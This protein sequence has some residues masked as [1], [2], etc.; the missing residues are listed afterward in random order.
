[1]LDSDIRCDAV[2][3]GAG[4]TGAM[5]ARELVDAG[6]DTV[7]VD[8]REAAW[9]STAAST[10][11][12]QYEID[13]P[14]TDLTAMRGRDQAARAYFACR[15]AV[16]KLEQVTHV[17]GVD[18]GFERKRSLYLATR[19]EDRDKLRAECEARREIGIHVDFLSEDDISA[20]FPFRRPAALLSYDAAQVDTYAFAHAL[21]RYGAARGLRVFD[22]TAVVDVEASDRGV[23]ALTA[24]RCT[25]RARHL[26]F[27]SG[28]ETRDFLNEPV[29]KL[30]STY[31]FASEPLSSRD[32]WG[33][34]ECLI[35]E[36]ARP[37][38]YLRTTSDHRIVVGGEDEPFRDPKR[39]DRLL[40]AKTER[41]VARSKELL[42]GTDVRTAFA[43]TGTFGET[44]DGL[45]YIGTHPDWPSSY[46][47]LCYGG[48]GITFGVLAAEIVRD[49]VRGRHHPNAD[50]FRFER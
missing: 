14:L 25:V 36:C 4:I 3:L 15:D 44:K 6:F 10:G 38:L 1:M 34:D 28:Y 20:L 46:F 43:W 45:A 12:L 5:V 7:V 30:A 39:R 2:V 49:A 35:W 24:N 33:E 19:P 8:R 11:L 26:V 27:A 47:A 40:A 23:K 42:P 50:L 32:A 31:A 48:N 13:V 21:L 9:G 17:V 41:L 18:V 29:A 16:A 22:R 37:Y